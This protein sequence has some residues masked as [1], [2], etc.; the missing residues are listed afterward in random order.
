L[1]RQSLLAMTQPVT[2]ATI[3]INELDEIEITL[4]EDNRR[5]GEVVPV[6]LRAAVTEASTLELHAV[7]QKDDGQW[8]IE[9]DVQAG[10]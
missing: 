4:A 6:H 10:E 1:L 2:T 8:K 9:F 5:A 3:F 7:S